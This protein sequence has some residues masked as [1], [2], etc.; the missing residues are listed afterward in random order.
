MS[1]FWSWKSRSPQSTMSPWL[2]HTFFR[3]LPRI[4]PR[5]V[6]PSKQS[7]SSRPFPSIRTTCAYSWP[8]SL[9]I[10]SR[11]CARS[12]LLKAQGGSGGG[13]S[14]AAHL[15]LLVVLAAARALAYLPLVLRHAV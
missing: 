3:I 8:S 12:V 13:V 14:A 11:F 10:S 4:C 2:T 7:A 9:K 5:R 6:L 15:P 1:H